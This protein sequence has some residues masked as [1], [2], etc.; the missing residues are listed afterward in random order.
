MIKNSTALLLC[1]IAVLTAYII[2]DK[3]LSKNS[4]ENGL[5]KKQ[6][7]VNES[8]SERFSKQNPT[9]YKQQNSNNTAPIPSLPK[10]NNIVAN[11]PIPIEFH[12]TLKP[13]KPM[14]RR[15]CMQKKD[16]LGLMYC[17][18][19][20][21]HLAGAALACGHLKNIPSRYEMQEF[22]KKIYN[23]Y[24]TNPSIYG[25]RN[26]E[27][28]KRMNIFANDSHIFYWVGE[29]ETPEDGVVRMFASKGSLIYK[30]YRDGSGYYSPAVGKMEFGQTRYIRTRNPE[31]DSN[32]VGL[33]NEDVLLLLCK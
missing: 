8:I 1:I 7:V 9:D 21:D 17:P 15:E 10:Q 6:N 24:T 26:D 20:N 2:D 12:Y 31:H 18:T 27:E 25:T 23:N 33:P 22:A 11:E 4:V 30:A 3:F 14:S 19:E 32:L 13:Y 16:E 29:E 28:L 5:N